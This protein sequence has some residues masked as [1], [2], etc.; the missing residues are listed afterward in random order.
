MRNLLTYIFFQFNIKIMESVSIRTQGV[1]AASDGRPVV[2]PPRLPYAPAGS[3]SSADT[4]EHGSIQASDVGTGRLQDRALLPA[5]RSFASFLASTT[6]YDA[7][8]SSSKVVVFDVGVPLRLAFYALVE[9]EVTAAPLWDS[10]R[11]EFA[12]M[13]TV[14]DFSQILLEYHKRG[15]VGSSSAAQALNKHTLA[16]WKRF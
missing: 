1:A 2:I 14:T 9:N 6:C 15:T 8:P 7:L 12:G 10:S 13:V 4:G 3:G 5:R 11:G 16:S